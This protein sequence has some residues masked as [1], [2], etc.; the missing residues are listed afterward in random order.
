MK[1]LLLCG[2]C[3]IL[4]MVINMDLPKRKPTRLKDFDYSTHGAYFVT[5]CTKDK[6][7]L[8]CEIV[9]GGT[10]DAPK[11]ILSSI[12]EVVEKYI[13][14]TN[15]IENVTVDKY[16]VMPNHIHMIIFVG[17]ADGTSRAPSPTNATIPHLVSTLKR[18]VN[19]EVGYN[20]FQ[21]SFYD[22]IIRDYKDYYYR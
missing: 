13:N 3:D 18:F 5:I 4:L 11:I 6:A 19:R 14:S 20:I 16:V 12:G 15:N 21:R 1:Q 10:F 7:K 9:G 8:L 2:F 17:N 22:H